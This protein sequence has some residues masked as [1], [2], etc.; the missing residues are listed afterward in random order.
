MQIEPLAK[1]MKVPEKFEIQNTFGISWGQ[2]RFWKLKPMKI[3]SYA[4]FSLL[5]RRQVR[6]SEMSVRTSDFK[7]IRY[8]RCPSAS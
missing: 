8:Q 2:K 7:D 4:G 6:L 3:L 5:L 1:G